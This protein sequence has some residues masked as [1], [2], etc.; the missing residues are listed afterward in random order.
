M[1][2]W[3]PVEGCACAAFE[4]AGR[5]LSSFVGKV[6]SSGPT[7]TS[8][9]GAELALAMNRRS[10]AFEPIRGRSANSEV[11]SLPCPKFTLKLHESESNLQTIK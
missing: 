6:G 5:S 2:K 11:A 4:A 8:L 3:R 1:W 10:L 7:M 9:I